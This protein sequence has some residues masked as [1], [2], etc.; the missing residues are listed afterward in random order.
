[1][2]AVLPNGNISSGYFEWPAM[3]AWYLKLGL[4]K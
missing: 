1:M 4:M 3:K 2:I